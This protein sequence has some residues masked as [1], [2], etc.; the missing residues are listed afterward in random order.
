MTIS[1]I[2]CTQNPTSAEEYR[3]KW[4]PEIIANKT[5][6]DSVLIIGA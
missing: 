6:D 1:P 2:R 4:H 5:T 3:R